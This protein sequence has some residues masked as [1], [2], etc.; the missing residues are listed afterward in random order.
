M[1]CKGYEDQL[2]DMA[3]DLP[4]DAAAAREAAAHLE[5]CDAC[6]SRMAE[7]RALTAG[8]RAVARST[9]SAHPS[10]DID[11][12]L[13]HALSE[14]HR[15][16]AVR[17]DQPV[18]EWRAWLA[19]AAAIAILAA[20]LTLAWQGFERTRQASVVEQA[21]SEFVPWPGAASL[22][23]FE[24]GAL[25][26][27]ELPAAVLPLL[28]IVPAKATQGDT[29]TADVLVGQDGLARAVRLARY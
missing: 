19:V 21:S 20:G 2:L 28:G 6:R 16:T 13:L 5:E 11:A 10:G 9:E 1:T 14:Q 3:R 27:T 8:L 12:R 17:T 7:A 25:V 4:V 23:P 26:R 15:A 22:P 24:S 18:A 29:V